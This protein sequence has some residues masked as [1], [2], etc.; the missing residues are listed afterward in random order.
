MMYFAR[1]AVLM[2]CASGWVS[3]RCG[4]A[5]QHVVLPAAFATLEG[6]FNNAGPIGSSGGTMQTMYSVGE[7]AA[8]PIGSRITA[9]QLRQDNNFGFSPWPRLDIVV[10]DYRVYMGKSNRTPATFST[11]FAN[12]IIDK[13]QVKAG[14]LSLIKNAYPGAF[15]IGGTTPKGWGPVITLDTAYTYQGGPLVIEWRNPGAGSNGGTSADATSNS[16]AA[17]GGG[18]STSPEATTSNGESAAIVRLTYLPP[19]CPA[20]FNNDTVVDDAD[21]QIFVLAYNI[22]DCNDPA[23]PA[24]CPADLNADAVV[25]DTDFQIFV[26]AYNELLCS[27]DEPSAMRSGHSVPRWRCR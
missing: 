8:V 10:A 25:D 5:E 4:A 26:V 6:A 20:D 3:A 9:F 23:M 22:L 11:T 24:G 13:Q 27:L 18:N 17:A 19:G 21:F 1:A 14:P 15:P 16:A 7:M 2:A 12:N